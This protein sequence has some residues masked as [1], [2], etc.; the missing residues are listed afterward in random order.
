MEFIAVVVEFPKS[1]ADSFLV[2]LTKIGDCPEV[3][4]QTVNK[5]YHFD[6][7]SAFTFEPSGRTD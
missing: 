6:V 2:V 4:C 1:F 5:P 3:R 7:A